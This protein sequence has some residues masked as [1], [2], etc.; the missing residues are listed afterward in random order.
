MHQLSNLLETT[1]VCPLC[2]D[3]RQRALFQIADMTF[4]S[5]KAC[6]FRFMNPHLSE[7]GMNL[8]YQGPERYG[9]TAELDSR[10]EYGAEKAQAERAGTI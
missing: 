6:G 8:A 5:C 3:G 9:F 2:G 10:Y 7:E 1:P 4:V